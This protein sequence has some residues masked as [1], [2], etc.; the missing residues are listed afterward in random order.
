MARPTP[1]HRLLEVTGGDLRAANHTMHD[2]SRGTTRVALGDISHFC[3]K[4]VFVPI[5]VLYHV[6][7]ITATRDWLG[8]LV[9]LLFD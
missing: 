2:G 6:H 8:L 9:Q 4:Q 1:D 5:V 3:C 7:C